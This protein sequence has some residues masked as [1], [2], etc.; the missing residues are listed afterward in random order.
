MTAPLAAAPD[1]LWNR[2]FLLWWLGS[3]QSA[4]G[5]A[6]AGIATSFLVLHQTGSASAMGLNL[7]LA[8]LPAL[9]EPFLGAWVDRIPLKIPLVTGN[10]LRGLLQLG[11][12]FWALQGHLPTEAIYAASFLTGLVGAFYTPATQGMVARLVPA[13]QLERATGLMQGGTQTMTMLGLVA[14][15]FLVAT[16]GRAQTLLLDGLS[17][18]IFAGLLLLVQLPAR[19]SHAADEPY[20][21][22]FKAG[23]RYVRGST[24]LMGL[25]LLALLLNASFAPINMLLPKRMQSLGAGE[26]GYGLFFGLMLAGVAGGSFLVAALGQRV[27]ARIASVAGMT[28][29]GLGTLALAFTQTAPQMY[30]LAVCMGLGNAFCNMGI[31]VIFQKKVAP[32]Y[33]GRVGSLLGMV[34]MVGMP[35]TLLALT[36]FADRL[37]ISTIFAV[38]GSVTVLGA[39]AWAG[40]LRRDG[41]A[42]APAVSE[43]TP[44]NNS[45]PAGGR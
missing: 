37:S 20:W 8:M 9:L 22:T 34:V 2:N 3:A 28:V 36:P 14:G 44:E 27:N 40:I 16:L 19:A 33:F 45:R 35:L 39:L 13:D 17:F 1:K 7:A 41:E 24:L 4:F 42:K 23:V 31:G 21:D 29:M 11:L 30:A 26:G 15:G 38:C 6:L 5:T 32:E 25:P 10:V 18:L 12:G 43:T